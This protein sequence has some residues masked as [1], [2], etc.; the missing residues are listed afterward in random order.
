LASYPFPEIELEHECDPEPQLNNLIS[1]F[2][3]ILTLVSLP[4]FN[5]FPDSVLN[6][7]PVHRKI[8]SPI[9]HDQYIELDQYYSFESSIDKLTSF[10]FYEIELNQ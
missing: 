9:F 3:S 5:R 1:L 8:E 6:P 7:V 2:D 4:D 10:Y